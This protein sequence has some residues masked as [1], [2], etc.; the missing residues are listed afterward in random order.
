M[1]EKISERYQK[2]LV[3]VAMGFRTEDDIRK[4]GLYRFTKNEQS[5]LLEYVTSLFNEKENVLVLK[6]NQRGY[7]SEHMNISS[8]IDLNNFVRN[9]ANIY[10]EDNELWVV[11]SSSIECWRGR[12]YLSNNNSNDIIEMAY[13]CDDHILDHID[14]SLKVPYV[15]YKKEGNSFKVSN[16]NLDNNTIQI[17][18]ATLKDIL[19]R[20]SD[21]F[22]EIKEDLGFIGIDGISLDVR[23]NNGYDF[24]DFDVSFESIKKV[25]DYYLPQ[26]DSVKKYK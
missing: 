6:V 19:Y 16:T 17:T 8:K 10:D 18:D 15:C 21:K 20:Y 5:S 1:T 7:H 12:I 11:S 26:L 14:S 23:V 24:H 2:A 22:R 9:I 13:S 4:N 3:T 25:I